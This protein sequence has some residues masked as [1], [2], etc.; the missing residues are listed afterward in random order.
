MHQLMSSTDQL[1]IVDVD[2]LEKETEKEI[3]IRS[4]HSL[5]HLFIYLFIH[6]L[7]TVRNAVK[8]FSTDLIGDFRA[9]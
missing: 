6:S 3:N 7:L 4:Y 2:K 1:Q 9:K 5:L 8:I